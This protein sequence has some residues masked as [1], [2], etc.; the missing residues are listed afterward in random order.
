MASSFAGD[1]LYTIRR[2]NT[3]RRGGPQRA[4]GCAMAARGLHSRGLTGEKKDLV[5]QSPKERQNKALANGEKEHK[6]STNF[7]KTALMGIT[8]GHVTNQ[9]LPYSGVVVTD[10]RPRL[11]QIV[12]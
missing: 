1:T 8:A 5:L 7:Y 11:S 4:W 12:H 10:Q 6:K 9:L 3:N 2:E